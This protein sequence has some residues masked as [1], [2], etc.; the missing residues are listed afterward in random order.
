MNTTTRIAGS[1]A[2]IT[3]H[4]EID[5]DTLPSLRAAAAALPPGV[6]AVIWDLHDT[7]FMDV[8]GLHLLLE[9]QADPRRETSVRNLARQP[10]GLLVLTE[11]IAPTPDLARL[12]STLGSDAAAA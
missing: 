2:R 4:G 9:Q 12:R 3:P 6:T 10:L 7:L 11:E 1:T 8:A 5:Y